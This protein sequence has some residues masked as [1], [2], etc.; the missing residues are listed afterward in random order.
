[1]SEATPNRAVMERLRLLEAELLSIRQTLTPSAQALPEGS[2]QVLEAQVGGNWFGVPVSEIR[3]VIH[4][5]WLQAL[6]DSPAWI[7]GT[8][9]YGGE[10]VPIIDVPQRLGAERL[11]LNPSHR[12]VLAMTPA[13]TGFAFHQVG[14][15]VTLDTATV[16]PPSPA[17]NGEWF[18]LGSVPRSG[19]DAMHILSLERL[20]HGFVIT[21]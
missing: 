15:V 8:L 1:M 3:E 2:F 12:I 11:A 14:E 7:M 4:M 10:V 19:F 18:L 9:R 16:N 5:V 21:K 6:P 20:S 17:V 13:L